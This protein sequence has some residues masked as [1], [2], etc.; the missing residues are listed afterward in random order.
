VAD[1][2]D[3]LIALTELVAGALY[4]NGP[5][6]SSVVAP[7]RVKVYPGWPVPNVLDTDLLA[8][9]AHVSIYPR[10]EERNTTR[11]EGRYQ[12]NAITPPTLTAVVIAD[13][14]TIGGVVSTPQ[15]VMLLVN[16]Q[17]YSHQVLKNDTLTSIATALAALIPNAT[18]VE[19]V[20]TIIDAYQVSAQ[21][22]TSGT[23]TR[24][25]RTQERLIQL[26]IWAPTPA[27]RTAIAKLID[28]FLSDI[29]RFTLPD[30]SIARLIY[31]SSPITDIL[32]K[33]TIYRRDLYY[34]VEYATTIT[35]TFNTIGTTQV[36]LT[37]SIA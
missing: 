16:G 9:N 30:G 5:G 1:L 2:D 11:Y 18:A 31:R 28:P 8:G 34:S 36:T 32:Q 25:V 13:S 23:A 21:I 26:V 15:A 24:T 35:G 10:P 22:I 6:S 20:I 27:I 3:I 19:A 14:I 17:A 7:A 4:P 33:A 12:E 37:K 29:K